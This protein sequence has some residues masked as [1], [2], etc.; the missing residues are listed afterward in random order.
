M[1]NLDGSNEAPNSAWM[2][3]KKLFFMVSVFTT[4]IVLM[5]TGGKFFKCIDAL[6]YYDERNKLHD[7]FVW[8]VVTAIV[9]WILNKSMLMGGVVRLSKAMKI[10]GFFNPE[11]NEQITLTVRA[12]YFGID[13]KTGV[14]GVVSPYKTQENN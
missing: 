7:L 14:I 3:V 10:D 13:F 11:K 8:I 6:G 4:V 2:A 12:S 1:D 9:F 5:I